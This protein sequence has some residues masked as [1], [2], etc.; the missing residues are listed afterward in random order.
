MRTIILLS[1]L[2]SFSYCFAQ[3][4]ANKGTELIDKM[5]EV[6]KQ[7][8]TIS[9][10]TIMSERIKGKM[11]DKNTYFKINVSPRKVYLKQSFIGIK[12]EGL[13]LEG[14]NNNKLRISTIGFPWV[15]TNIEPCGSMARDKHHHTLLEAGFGY[16]VSVVSALKESNLANYENLC[17]YQG[18]VERDKHQCHKIIFE[19]PSFSYNYYTV[20]DNEKLPEIALKLKINDFMILEK[21]SSIHHYTDVKPGQK[22]IVP[23]T[24][25]KKMILYLDTELFLPIDIEVYDDQGLY[26]EYLYSDLKV[27][28]TFKANEFDPKN[29][30][31]HFK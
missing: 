6:N 14:E 30:E 9:L 17:T 13:Y 24:Y 19:N 26:A 23:N 29:P 5:I 1:V 2:T 15:H 31:Y 22:I 7:V 10:H 20:K 8:K 18:I 21:N 4:P 12:L 28:P 16:F 25:A 3:K 27:N 11:V